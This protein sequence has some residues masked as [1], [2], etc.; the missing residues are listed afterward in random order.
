MANDQFWWR[1]RR[2]RT[3]GHGLAMSRTG[4]GRQPREYI[5]VSPEVHTKV[6]QLAAVLGLTV[7]ATMD[8]LVRGVR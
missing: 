5:K 6:L 4:R 1:G 2:R 8:E 3:N 7:R